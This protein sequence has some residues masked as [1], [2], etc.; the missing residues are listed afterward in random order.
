MYYVGQEVSHVTEAGPRGSNG[1]AD[2]GPNVSDWGIK[3]DLSCVGGWMKSRCEEI[4]RGKEETHKSCIIRKDGKREIKYK[5]K[6]LPGSIPVKSTW[7]ECVLN[8][9]L[10]L[11]FC[12][13]ETH[14]LEMVRFCI[15]CAMMHHSEVFPLNAMDSSCESQLMGT[16]SECVTHV[17]WIAHPS[18]SMNWNIQ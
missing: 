15:N 5:S 13:G 6:Y 8:S 4:R 7:S 2:S 17:H 1:V 18:V 14:T 12:I 10:L 3:A 9:F 16:N 11:F